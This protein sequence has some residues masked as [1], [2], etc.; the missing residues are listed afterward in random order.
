[1]TS[2]IYMYNMVSFVDGWWDYS[3]VIVVT[4]SLFPWIFWCF[5]IV[6]LDIWYFDI[7]MSSHCDTL[8]PG[9]WY[10]VFGTLIRFTHPSRSNGER[11]CRTQASPA[12][13]WY[14]GVV[15]GVL[16]FTKYPWSGYY[17]GII[18]LILLAAAAAYNNSSSARVEAQA[19]TLLL[20]LL[21]AAVYCC[22]MCRTLQHY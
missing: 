15:S 6:S 12:A 14:P 18:L 21:I 10:Q 5:Y 11:R 4:I 9:I 3:V 16:N 1:M 19:P 8:I 20:D 7:L 17:Q 13:A 22:A 2:R